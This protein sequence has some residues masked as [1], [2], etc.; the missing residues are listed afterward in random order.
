MDMLQIGV[1]FLLFGIFS[2]K[3]DKYK[4]V[5]QKCHMFKDSGFVR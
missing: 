5:W 4:C 1:K 3:Y 2:S